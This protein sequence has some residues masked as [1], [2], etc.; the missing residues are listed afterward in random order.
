MNEEVIG[1]FVVIVI[2]VTIYKL[3]AQM[4]SDRG[5]IDVSE[6]QLAAEHALEE[7]LRVLENSLLLRI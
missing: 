4:D 1:L 3:V 5:S 7:L 6:H 2:S